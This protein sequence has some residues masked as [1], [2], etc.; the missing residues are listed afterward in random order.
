MVPS[1][2]LPASPLCPAPSQ[3]LGADPHCSFLLPPE[4]YGSG[5]SF[6][7]VTV[8]NCPALSSLQDTRAIQ[9]PLNAVYTFPDKEKH[10]F[11]PA[12]RKRAEIKH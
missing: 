9:P 10:T 5:T 3:Q 4:F 1:C 6:W 2:F 12:P 7:G 11:T 8:P